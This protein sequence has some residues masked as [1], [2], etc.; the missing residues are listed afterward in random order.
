MHENLTFLIEEIEARLEEVEA[1]T[2][3]ASSGP[4]RWKT[5]DDK[6]L[7]ELP[8]LVSDSK[9]IC[10]SGNSTQYYPT[11]GEDPSAEDAEFISSARED[12][13]WLCVKIRELIDE[14]Q[15]LLED[16]ELLQELEIWKQTRIPRGEEEYEQ[17]Q[18]A[19]YTRNS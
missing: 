13:P 18:Q 16:Q 9:T 19:S 8:R 7:E 11:E 17:Q 6:Y 10:W 3:R 12:I 15:E 5:K 2:A 14:A 1:R 4:W